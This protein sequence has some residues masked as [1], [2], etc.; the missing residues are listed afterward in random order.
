MRRIVSFGEWLAI[1]LAA[2]F[3]VSTLTLQMGLAGS[4]EGTGVFS[5][6]FRAN[7][8]VW[9]D[10]NDTLSRSGLINISGNASPRFKLWGHASPQYRSA[11]ID[12]HFYSNGE[13]S[14][15]AIIDLDQ[16]LIHQADKSIALDANTIS[17][18]FNFSHPAD[19]D[20]LLA[21]TIVDFLQ[22]AKDGT[23]PTPSHHS[24]ALPEPFPGRMQHFATG[25]AL[26]PFELIWVAAWCAFG[27]RRL[28]KTKLIEGDIT[29][30]A[31]P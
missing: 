22:A 25:T 3:L 31:P 18:L 19:R 28:R 6:M 1:L 17:S 5:Y 24:H 11:E 7:F 26:R 9:Y 20:R 27:L 14:G 21:T 29:G 4:G 16:M 2:L 8:Q 23:L 12:W 10:V 30:S 13:S 15:H